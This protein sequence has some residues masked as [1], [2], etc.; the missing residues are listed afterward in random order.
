MEYSTCNCKITQ[1]FCK[2][3]LNKSK[4]LR[5]GSI[6]TPIKH[7]IADRQNGRMSSPFIGNVTEKQYDNL[8][9]SLLYTN[10]ARQKPTTIQQNMKRLYMATL[11]ALLVV[12]ASAQEVMRKEKD[13]TYII[14]TTTLATSVTGYRGTTPLEITIKKNKIVQVKPLRNMETPKFFQRV[15]QQMVPKYAGQPVS[16]KGMPQVD[17][18]TGAT[19]SSKAVQENVRRG[20]AYYLKHK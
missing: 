8:E 20:V 15:N 19:L 1:F 11:I 14:N 9:I 10:F 16:K 7:Q 2:S 18:V 4:R 12:S 17:G 3:T 6:L 5:S 13:G